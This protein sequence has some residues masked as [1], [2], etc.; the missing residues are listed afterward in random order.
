MVELD[1]SVIS[2][3]SQDLNNIP[4]ELHPRAANIARIPEKFPVRLHRVLAQLK[5]STTSS[6]A[7]TQQ[8]EVAFYWYSPFLLHPACLSKLYKSGVGAQS[9]QRSSTLIFANAHRLS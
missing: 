1:G 6:N 7:Q 2:E 8:A 9:D 3:H 4:N 5:I